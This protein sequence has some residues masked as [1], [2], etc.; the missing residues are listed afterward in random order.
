MSILHDKVHSARKSS[1]CNQCGRR[2]EVGQRYRKQVYTD[3]GLQ[4][5]RAHEDCDAVANKIHSN[6]N[7]LSDESVCLSEGVDREDRLWITEE[8]PAVAARLWRSSVAN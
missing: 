2:I 6:G 7:L 8:Y 5:Y 4:T 3:G 1:L